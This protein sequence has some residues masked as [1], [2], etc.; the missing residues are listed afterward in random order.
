MKIAITGSS[1]LIGSAISRRLEQDG[2]QITRVV[3]SREGAA[4]PGAV[5]WKPSEGEIDA[6]GLAGH[7]A[8]IN[9][10]GENI[11]GIWTD[12]KKKRIRESRVRGTTLLAETL[13]S[14]EPA[15]RPATLVN[16]SGF[17]YYGDRPPDVP[18]TEDA[19]PGDSFLA[20]VVRDWENAMAPA[21]EA[22]IR[23]VML[24]FGLVVDPD[25]LLLQGMAASSRFGLGAKLGDGSQVFPW[26]TRDE[27]ANVVPFVLREESVRGPVNVAA[28]EKV[29]NEEF[30]DAV[31]RVVER[32]RVLKVPAFAVKMI[33]GLGEEILTGAW[34]VP[35][36]LQSAGYE[37]RDPELEP[38]LRRMLT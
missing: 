21:A 3:R 27:I 34:V 24:R 16:A 15:D 19:P 30:A 38:A 7:D 32:P 20:G 11:F 22:G 13:A 37:W 14:L 36:K 33:G 31:A 1:G 4:R 5:F 28:P 35:S 10:A 9:L 17:S 29:T 6:S 23:V 26:V 8:V 12:G 25:A 18:M 2:H